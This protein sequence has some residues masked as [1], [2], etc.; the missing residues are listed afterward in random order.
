M[1]TSETEHEALHPAHTPP[2]PAPR[3]PGNF[4]PR[5]RLDA[6]LDQVLATPVNLVVAPAGSG[7]TAAAAAWTERLSGAE[8]A[9]RVAW[10]RGDDPEMIALQLEAM[11]CSQIPD[12]PHAL[13]IDDAHLL[14]EESA[15][16][17]SGVLAADPDSVRLLLIGRRDPDVVPI[18][19]ALAGSARVLPVDDLRF[20]DREALA[21]VQAHHPGAGDD[22]V[23]AVLEQ[24][25]GWAAAL[26]LGSRALAGS[27][28][29]ADARA[30]L[31]ATR[32]PVLDYLLHEVFDGL[33]PD[34]RTVL[35]ATAQEAE[36]D[37][38]AAVL[39]S[40]LPDAPTLLDQAASAGL[41][42]TSYRDDARG[43]TGWR[44][45]PLLRDLLRRR[46]APTGPDWTAV[47]EAHHRACA[48][49]VDRRD[50]EQAV[51]HASLTGDLDLQ[52]RV[53]REFGSD[54]ITRG[55]RAPISAALTAIPLDVRSRH[56]DLLVLQASL[57]RAEGRIDAAKAATDR[58]LAA[59]S[60]NLRPPVSRD[61]EAQLA[62]LEVWQARYGWREAGPALA[63]GSAVLGCRHDA[64]VSAHDL[65][66]I[67]PVAAAWLTIEM[68]YF[69]T[70]LGEMELAA[71]HLQDVA[72]YTQQVDLPLLSR[73]VLA[74]RAVLEM[75]GGAYQSALATAESAAAYELGRFDPA[76]ARIHLVRGWA[77][78]Q[79]LRLDDAELALARFR[80]IPSGVLDPLL[81]AFGRLLQACL[82]TARGEVEEA[83]RVLDTRGDVPERLPRY[84]ARLDRLVRVVI[85]LSM[86][87]LT[88]VA[89]TARS[90]RSISA[91]ADVDA[92][93]VETIMRGLAG[94]EVRA[95]RELTDLLPE[96][97]D[98]P[99][100]VS[101]GAAVARVAFLQRAGTPAALQQARDLVPD[102]LSRAAPQKLLWMLGM[103]RM[104]SPG[105][106]DLLV[107][108]AEGPDPHPFAAPA[109]AALVG[110][111]RPYPDLVRRDS[112]YGAHDLRALLTARELEVLGQLALGGGNAD[113]ARALYVSE[114][115]VKTH[116]A[117]IYRKLEVDRRVDALRVARAHG[118]L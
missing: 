21:L 53:L 58:V 36:V 22:D 12:G 57:L 65:T 30:A 114:N 11:R 103:G 101:I 81:L 100:T 9:V 70:W 37:A 83:R 109:A 87:D 108:N 1:G 69:E 72:M 99:V 5:Q 14:T 64:E 78:L 10:T 104:V 20:S 35:L 82:L 86:G 45:H 92:R 105:F 94:D 56:P 16:L 32:Q 42:V 52:L 89:A 46:T 59:R 47:V 106:V 28:D 50:A 51:H 84:I 80:E 49:H 23:A 95:V 31:A 71:I 111:R 29:V 38:D 117:S 43:L 55:V 6:F 68:A 19:V 66:G 79:E 2:P 98:L 61:T 116:L 54:L 76:Q 97:V 112:S 17:L 24:A 8:P 113:L 44:Y 15:E 39:L 118:L 27:A 4:V 26:V 85:A 88:S 91:E 110:L 75:V 60:R 34:L 96:A 40:G 48:V 90:M 63:H 3:P 25:D 13:V 67:S 77:M 115:T 107:E 74:G 62:I 41:L 102:L 18:S 33:P 7:K 93:L 73:S